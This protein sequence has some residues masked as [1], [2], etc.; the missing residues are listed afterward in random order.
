ML[1]A[2]KLKSTLNHACALCA[3]YVVNIYGVACEGISNVPHRLYIIFYSFLPLISSLESLLNRKIIGL[4]EMKVLPLFTI[5]LFIRLRLR[6]IERSFRLDSETVECSFVMIATLAD[7]FKFHLPS[8]SLK[9]ARCHAPRIPP[10]ER[11]WMY[12]PYS[13]IKSC[14]IVYALYLI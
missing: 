10:G 12:A 14:I 6:G 8:E 9:R 4:C 2:T 7:V 3:M 1:S 11:L 13:M 5:K